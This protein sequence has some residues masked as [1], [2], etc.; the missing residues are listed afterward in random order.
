MSEKRN[1]SVCRGHELANALYSNWIVPC[2]IALMDSLKIRCVA[3]Q[4]VESSRRVYDCTMKMTKTAT[5]T[6]GSTLYYKTEVY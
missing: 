6:P 4:I 5:S 1:E 2:I 3:R